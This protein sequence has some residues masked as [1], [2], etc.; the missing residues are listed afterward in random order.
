MIEIRPENPLIKILS[1]LVLFPLEFL[2]WKITGYYST[3]GNEKS[4][5][6]RWEIILHSVCA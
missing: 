6:H 2:D 3:I 1:N 5:C 4:K